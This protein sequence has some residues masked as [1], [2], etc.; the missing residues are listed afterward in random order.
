MKIDNIVIGGGMAGAYISRELS[1]IENSFV[2]LEA[3]ETLGGRHKT[4]KDDSGKVK[5]EAGAWRVHSSHSRMLKLCKELGLTLDSYEKS[6]DIYKGEKGLSK[7][8]S[9]I[10]ENDGDVME[11]F[12]RE[13]ETGYQGT[14]ESVSGTH[15]Y[16]TDKEGEFFT[17][18]EGQEEL[19]TRMTKE[20][21]PEK[22][23]LSHKVT[24]IEYSKNVYT[25]SVMF[26]KNRGPVNHIVITCDN[27]FCCVPQ[28]DA[29]G[30]KVSKDYLYPLLESVK[31]LSLHHIYATSKDFTVVKRANVPGSAL[32]QVLPPTHDKNWFQ[33][34]YSSGRIADFWYNY[35]MKH[36]GEKMKNLVEKYLLDIKLDKIESYYWS[37]AYHTWIATP[38]FDLEKSVKGS[39]HPNP[40]KLPNLWWAGECFSGYQGWSEGALQTAKM[41]IDDYMDKRTGYIPLYKNVPQ[42]YK[43]WMIFDGRIL[44]LKRWKNVHP[45][46]KE[47]IV[48]HLK[49]D[50]SNLFRFIKH[51]GLSWATLYSLQVGFLVK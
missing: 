28:F 38:Y 32:Q 43:E 41:A 13:L 26:R 10:I 50:V 19:I 35:K 42:K 25:V 45:G 14:Y 5:Y 24:D 47:A 6:R 3:S 37:H 22:I 8:D 48:G 11:A 2:L 31:P 49:E 16:S 21:D 17:V 34:S 27:I 30:W 40:L 44:D 29:W 4:V 23:K 18:K 36:G 39:I 33:A 9:L 15:P 12:S 51:S 20:I 1:R 7:L 46:T